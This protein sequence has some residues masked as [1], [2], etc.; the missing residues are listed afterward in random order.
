MAL[1]TVMIGK[2]DDVREHPTQKPEGLI[3]VSATSSF[4]SNHLGFPAAVRQAFGREDGPQ[5]HRHRKSSRAI[6]TLLAAAF[7]TR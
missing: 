3:V 5:I 7:P 1:E 2:G 6:S 4:E